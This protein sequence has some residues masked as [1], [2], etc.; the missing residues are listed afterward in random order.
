MGYKI[1]GFMIG[2]VIVG[3]FIALS[4]LLLSELDNTYSFTYDNESYGSYNRLSNIT[5]TS[6]EVKESVEDIKEQSGILDVVGGYFSSAYNSLKLVS[7]S[8][9]AFEGLTNEAA[10]DVN[11]GEGGKLIRDTI[12]TITIIVVFIG[13]LIGAIMKIKEGDL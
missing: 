3:L 4:G 11:L 6:K 10:Q 5:S 13:I 9:N 1:T 2:I 12:V 7:K 8:F